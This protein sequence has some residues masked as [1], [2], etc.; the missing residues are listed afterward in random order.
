MP[1][2]S[3]GSPAP[4]RKRSAVSLQVKLPCATLDA[5]SFDADLPPGGAPLITPQQPIPVVPK[6]RPAP[7]PM[8]RPTLAPRTPDAAQPIVVEDAAPAPRPPGAKKGRIIGIDLGTT[9]STA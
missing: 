9:N 4:P 8:P 6:A 1:S 3:G 2:M 7:P 5:A